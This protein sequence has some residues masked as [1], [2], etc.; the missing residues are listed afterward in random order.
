MYVPA[1]VY[2]GG[3]SAD[4]LARENLGMRFAPENRRYQHRYRRS[5]IPNREAPQAM[6]DL[7]ANLEGE[8]IHLELASP[9]AG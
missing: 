1:R 6:T 3:T 7:V 5:S 2:A 9:E 8:R 4:H